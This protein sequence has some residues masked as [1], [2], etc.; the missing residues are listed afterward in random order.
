MGR[1]R[2]GL[3]K[4]ILLEKLQTWVNPD[5]AKTIRQTQG[6]YFLTEKKSTRRTNFSNLFWK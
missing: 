2:L 6:F 5:L 1:F 3:G 4:G